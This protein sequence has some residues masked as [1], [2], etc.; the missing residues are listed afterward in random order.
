MKNKN[1]VIE[2][3]DLENDDYAE[4]RKRIEILDIFDEFDTALY[5]D[6]KFD[7]VEYEGVML[8]TEK[9]EAGE[10][11]ADTDDFF[12]DVLA[13]E[14]LDHNDVLHYL[15]DESNAYSH[16]EKGINNKLFDGRKCEWEFER[17]LYDVFYNNYGVY[18][19]VNDKTGE[20]LLVTIHGSRHNLNDSS[21]MFS[22]ANEYNKWLNVVHRGYENGNLYGNANAVIRVLD[23]MYPSEYSE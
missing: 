20:V 21:I 11:N 22:N 23:A 1:T 12:Y 3:A 18:K 13:D 16:R 9:M 17:S 19:Y 15:L 7:G 5:L 2:N 4:I 14:T 10:Y 8:D 6:I